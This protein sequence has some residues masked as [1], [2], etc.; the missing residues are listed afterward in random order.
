VP[1]SPLAHLVAVLSLIVFLGLT[2]AACEDNDTPGTADPFPEREH[3]LVVHSYDDGFR[4]TAQLGKGIVDGLREAGLREGLEYDLR[5]FFMDTRV[6]Y[7]T[8]DEVK[9]RADQALAMIDEFRPRIVFLTDDVA[10]R[11]VG[12]RYAEAHPDTDIAFVFSGINVDPSTYP[13]IQSLQT[14]GGVMTGLL[15]RIPVADAATEVKR[16]FPSAT[17][18]ALLADGSASSAAA[19]DDFH[20]T[21]PGGLHD[22][23]EVTGFT[24]VKTFAEWQQLVTQADAAAD[25]IGVLN[26]HGLTDEAGR[27]VPSSEVLDWML[28]HST[29]PV[30]GLITDWAQDGLPMA[31]GNSGARN[32]E[33]AAKI[34]VDILQGADPGQI[35]IVY[36][37]L[38]ESAFNLRAIRELGLQIPDSVI[39]EAGLV[40][41]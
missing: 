6:R 3:I 39:A 35:P 34:A 12:V 8:A 20:A 21:Y 23:L 7:T 13:T 19:I 36:P 11:E 26:Y 14:P 15:E 9:A 29:K 25:V 38:V 41:R 37:G 5:V 32:G 28:E 33:A 1:H 17:R 2:A 16:A 24:Q 27:P 40:V 18:L 22:P 31:V 4:W 10:L 30:V